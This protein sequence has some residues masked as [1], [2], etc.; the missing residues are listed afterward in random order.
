MSPSFGY[1]FPTADRV[2]KCQG[3]RTGVGHWSKPSSK[4]ARLSQ[5]RKQIRLGQFANSAIL[6]PS[7][8]RDQSYVMG[9]DYSLGRV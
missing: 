5:L 7:I 9:R 8:L 4:A 6:L 1:T 2:S 3:V